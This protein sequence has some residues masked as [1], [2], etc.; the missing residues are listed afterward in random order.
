MFITLKEKRMIQP[1]IYFPIGVS[2]AGKSTYLKKLQTKIPDLQV[3]SLDTLR[4]EFYDPVD[5]AKAFSA[6]TK[7]K[8]FSSRANQ[9]FIDMIA[10]GKSIYIDNTNLTAKRRRFYLDVARKNGYK[11][12]AILM[13]V[14]I[15]TLVKRQLTRGDKNVP[16]DAVRRQF[17]SLQSPQEGEFDSV[18]TV[19][20]T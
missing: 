5:Y 18:E 17:A 3:F 10:T 11:T 12:H 13:P 8:E 16:E 6:S 9:R 14:D 15:E 7:D 4:H 2:G 20:T 1:T 19:K